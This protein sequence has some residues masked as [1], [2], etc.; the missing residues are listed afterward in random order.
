MGFLREVFQ[1]RGEEISIFYSTKYPILLY[2]YLKQ[3]MSQ[4]KY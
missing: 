3:L 4:S 2:T 1:G